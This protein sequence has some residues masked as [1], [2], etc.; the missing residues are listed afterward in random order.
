MGDG[1]PRGRRRLRRIRWRSDVFRNCFAHRER[2]KSGRVTPDS[3]HKNRFANLAGGLI[4]LAR[5]VLPPGPDLQLLEDL[6]WLGEILGAAGLTSSTTQTASVPFALAD[7]EQLWA[8]MT[9]AAVRSAA[10]VERLSEVGI[11]AVRDGVRRRLERFRTA[12]GYTVT[13]N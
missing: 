12:E 5:V 2:F 9:Q 7:E 1:G 13:L 10:L 6:A 11:A 4:R 8:V 3:Q